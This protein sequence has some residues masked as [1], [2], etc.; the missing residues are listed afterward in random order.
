[1]NGKVHANANGAQQDKT[2]Q[3]DR[4]DDCDEMEETID[5]LKDEVFA[6]RQLI[7]MMRT[8]GQYFDP[9]FLYNKPNQKETHRIC[10][11]PT[12]GSMVTGADTVYG[13][14]STIILATVLWRAEMGKAI[15]KN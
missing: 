11:A 10:M 3:G 8:K 13:I 2:S 15:Q 6:Q 5:T 14:F 4:G 7:H 1:M 9:S 12:E